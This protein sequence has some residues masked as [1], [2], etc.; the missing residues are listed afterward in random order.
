MML[1]TH[2][3]ISVL[4]IILILPHV[5]NKLIFAFVVL[6]ATLLPDI[7]TGYSTI[8]KFPGFKILQFFFRH[9]GVLH[10]LSFCIVASFVL[11]FFLPILAFPFFLGYFL[12]I[13]SDSFNIEGIKPFWPLA[14]KSSGLLRT[15]SLLETNLFIIFL[16]ADVF[17]FIFRYNTIF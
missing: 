5:S 1:R 17:I 11:A 2:L 14:R 8:G 7:D 13:F 15:G 16:L 3:S 10:S 6:V 12:H 9:R 4:F